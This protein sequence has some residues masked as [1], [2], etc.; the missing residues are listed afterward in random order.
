MLHARDKGRGTGRGKGRG[1]GRGRGGDPIEPLALFPSLAGPDPVEEL[2][3]V[4]APLAAPPLLPGPVV[5]PAPPV[6]T[7]AGGAPAAAEG[8]VYVFVGHL[9]DH[10]ALTR[11]T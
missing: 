3:V 2:A 8:G 9:Y 6:A 1:K 10:T 5:A 7:P 4:L 11:A